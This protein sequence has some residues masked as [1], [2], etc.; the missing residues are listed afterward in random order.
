MKRYII[1]FMKQYFTIDM[2]HILRC[3]IL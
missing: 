2:R 1:Y 3:S